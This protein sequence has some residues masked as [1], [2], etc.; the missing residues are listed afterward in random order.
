MGEEGQ[1]EVP[2]VGHLFG[3]VGPSW[4]VAVKPQVF[5]GRFSVASSLLG[6]MEKQMDVSCSP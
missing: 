4:V 5:L 6:T 3:K 1:K 2:G